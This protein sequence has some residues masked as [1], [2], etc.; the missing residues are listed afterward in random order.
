MAEGHFG[1]RALGPCSFAASV[2]F[3][4]EFAPAAYEG[5]G[6]GRLRMAF[7][8]DGGEEVARVSVREEGMV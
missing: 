5:G 8:A 3:L 1:L 7:V 4:E 6:L 2:R